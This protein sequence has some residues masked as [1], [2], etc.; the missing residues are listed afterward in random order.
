LKGK[1]VIT[2]RNEQPGDEAQIYE[3]N[4]QAFERKQEAEVVDALRT[5]CP[6]GVSLVAEEDGKLV[7]HILF[8]PT[9]IESEGRS[10]MGTGLA[11]MAV[12]PRYQRRGIGS[13]LVRA[14]LEAMRKAGEPFVIVVGHPGF[15]PKFGFER[16]SK[17]GIRCEY[18]QVPDEAFMIVVYDEDKIKG[19]N[20]VA[21]E[22]PEFAAAI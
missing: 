17:Y 2:I 15:Y 18:D 8:T 19:I 5:S 13:A 12:L 7:G 22:R 10:I 20:G 14:G 4:Y 21:K 1:N 3:V 6:E 11:P 9:V 16:A